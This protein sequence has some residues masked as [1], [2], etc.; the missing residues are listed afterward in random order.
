MSSQ[1]S[2][3]N[4][5]VNDVELDVVINNIEVVISNFEIDL[6]ID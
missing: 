2:I 4:I 5:E 6:V 1:M 3:I